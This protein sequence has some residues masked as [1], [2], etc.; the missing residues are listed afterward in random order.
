ME[1][2]IAENEELKAEVDR[3]TIDN[4]RLQQDQYELTHLRELM[5]LDSEYD[6]LDTVGARV[7][8]RDAGNWYSSFV[9]DKGSND[10]ISVDCNVIAG[11]GLVGRVTDVGPDFAKV[12]SIISDT[13]NTS[14]MILSTGDT[15][16][17]SGSLKLMD[18]N[19]ISFGQLV[20]KDNKVGPGD[21][22]VTSNIS[23]KYLEGIFIGYVNTIATDSNNL[24]KSGTLIPAA[25]FKHL[26]EVLVI[27]KTKKKASFE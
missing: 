14:G 10:G 7:I 22:I 21:K 27:K 1:S 24:T 2:V 4:A 19:L 11:S 12:V 5:E 8:S 6:D 17:V 23:D 20:D 3:L 13:S 16:I 26:E 15:L 25:D 18:S 9:I